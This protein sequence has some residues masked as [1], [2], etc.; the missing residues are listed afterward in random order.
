MKQDGTISY[1]V[2]EINKN[3][4]MSGKYKNWNYCFKYF[5]SY[6]ERLLIL[7]SVVTLCVSISAFASLVGFPKAIASSVVGLK[8]C[9]IT[10]RI[11][12]I[13]SQ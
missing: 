10:S 11:Q 12:K 7:A 5:W 13:I 1:L 2:E 4:L 8:T 6:S 9:A 3:D